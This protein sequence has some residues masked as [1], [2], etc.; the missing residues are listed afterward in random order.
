MWL[1]A[2]HAV[3]W[4]RAWKTERHTCAPPCAQTQANQGAPAPQEAPYLGSSANAR[5]GSKGRL[6]E[7][8]MRERGL[9]YD[10]A[11]FIDDTREEV[12][13][14]EP[15]C[16]T[17]LVQPAAGMGP[18]HL[19]Q[20]RQMLPRPGPDVRIEE[21][22]PWEPRRSAAAHGAPDGD[23]ARGALCGGATRGSALGGKIEVRARQVRFLHV[24]VCACVRKRAHRWGGWGLRRPPM[25]CGNQT[26]C[27]PPSH[28]YDL[29][30]GGFSTRPGRWGLD[31]KPWSGADV[32][33]GSTHLLLEN[34]SCGH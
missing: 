34:R 32:G 5:W 21:G 9:Q 29:R 2:P 6:I 20:L 33:V 17:I 31:G 3:E 18:E 13:S 14:A 26:G 8:C 19:E 1:G 11:V 7:Q 24:C 10:E 15:V 22:S 27:A 25:G 23:S 28:G 4:P 12:Q 30:T 16:R